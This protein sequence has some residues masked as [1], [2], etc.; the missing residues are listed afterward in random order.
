MHIIFKE[1]SPILERKGYRSNEA[2]RCYVIA[3]TWQSD[4]LKIINYKNKSTKGYIEVDENF[5]SQE[6]FFNTIPSK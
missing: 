3:D 4:K 1:K 6:F 5:K 2:I